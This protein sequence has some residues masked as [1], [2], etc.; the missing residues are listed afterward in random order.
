M[1]FHETPLSGAFIVELEP[2]RD[3]RGFFANAYCRRQFEEAGLNPEVVQTNFSF[4]RLKGTIRGM[5]Y[6]LPPAAETKFVRCIKGAIYDVVVDLR[7]DSSSYLQHF[8]VELTDANRKALYIPAMFGHGYLTLEDCTEVL[9]QV[10]E[11][12]Q[13]ECERGF[14][15]DDPAFNISWPLPISVASD[16]DTTWPAF[17][18]NDV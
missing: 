7:K 6:Q 14:R 15:Y 2:R 8:A 3:D 12:Y 13:P 18:I 9:Y 16:K 5:H 10:G 11:Y 1:E 17:P 4:S